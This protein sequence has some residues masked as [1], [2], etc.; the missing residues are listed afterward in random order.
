M[1]KTKTETIR[2][3]ADSRGVSL[4]VD[5]E[6]GIIHGVKILGL[7]SK[8]GRVYSEAAVAKAMPLYEGARSNVDHAKTGESV[9]Y[10]ARIGSLR[11]VRAGEGGLYADFHFNPKHALAEQLMWDAENAPGNV[12]F[13]H[14]VQAKTK[15]GADGRVVIEE[16]AK[17]ASVDLVANPATTNGLY[18]EIEMTNS[19][20]ASA[21][22]ACIAECQK[23]IADC[24]KCIATCQ[25]CL[26]DMSPAN[27][28]ACAADCSACATACQGC[29]TACS[30][31]ATAC[32][33]MGGAKESFI[34][35]TDKLQA[36]LH[37]LREQLSAYAAREAES[38]KNAAIA[39]ELTA[40]K[41]DSRDKVAVSEAFLWQLKAAPD[42]A[43]RKKLIEDR[44]AIL[45]LAARSSVV[46][47]PPFAGVTEGASGPGATMQETLARL[48]G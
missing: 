17:V 40:A 43:G 24:Q 11:N 7:E 9:S 16:I 44:I 48:R 46:T 8:N 27:C 38:A 28:S 29:D 15:R 5:K 23:C 26:D 22:R 45:K 6:K 21:C 18:E 32:K 1:P 37:A 39:E 2:E 35:H 33:S 13:S 34:P 31:C 4:K 12:G 10:T 19:D 42:A 14:D 47:T 41:F 3:F 25:E 30:A 36:Q 20:C